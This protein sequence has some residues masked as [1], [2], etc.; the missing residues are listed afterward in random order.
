MGATSGG[1]TLLF[2]FTG[3]P[4]SRNLCKINSTIIYTCIQ[5]YMFLFGKENSAYHLT[6]MHENKLVLLMDHLIYPVGCIQTNHR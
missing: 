3:P 1:I 2:S 6:E 4:D 5:G